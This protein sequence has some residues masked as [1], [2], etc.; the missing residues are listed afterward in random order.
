M[1]VNRVISQLRP[2]GT[3]LKIVSDGLCSPSL[4]ALSFDFRL[5]PSEIGA[6]GSGYQTLS[7][8][9]LS[10]KYSSKVRRL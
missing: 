1:T 10:G 7:L 4:R 2:V 3:K 5:I 6:L 8:T 9:G